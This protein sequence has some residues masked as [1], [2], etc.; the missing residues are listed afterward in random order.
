MSSNYLPHAQFKLT[1]TSQIKK[2]DIMRESRLSVARSNNKTPHSMFR[3]YS[4]IR[5]S[6]ESSTTRYS[7]QLSNFIRI[8]PNWTSQSLKLRTKPGYAPLKLRGLVMDIQSSDMKAKTIKPLCNGES[9]KI[10]RA[11]NKISKA[12]YKEF[13]APTN[14]DEFY[15]VKPRIQ[16]RCKS[17]ESRIDSPTKLPRRITRHRSTFYH[18]EIRTNY[19]RIPDLQSESRDE[20]KSQLIGWNIDDEHNISLLNLMYE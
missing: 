8:K 19:K 10:R 3:K 20:D 6:I 13:S 9:P 18:P 1:N 17:I 12:D 15:Y 5:N 4:N 2:F 14:Y 7:T 11:K 16:V